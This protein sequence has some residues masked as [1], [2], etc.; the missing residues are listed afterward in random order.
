MRKF[1]FAF[2]LLSLVFTGCKKEEEKDKPLAEYVEGDWNMTSI[3]GQA[4]ITSPFINGSLVATG[5]DVSG[6][7][8]FRSN[9]KVDVNMS[10]RM[11]L[12]IDGNLVDE[13]EDPTVENFTADYKVIS[14]T[15]IEITEDGEPPIM[16]TVRNRENTSFEL[17]T[18]Q[19]MD[20]FGDPIEYVI[21]TGLRR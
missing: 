20:E 17:R 6:K 15:Q 8:T 12:T 16:L 19:Q 11:R 13:E 21:T 5:L 2:G 1:L 9:G 7:W 14:D 3:R 10:Y 4:E 18:S